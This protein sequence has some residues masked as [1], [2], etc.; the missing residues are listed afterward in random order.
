[1]PA[2]TVPAIAARFDVLEVAL[3]V[4]GSTDPLKVAVTVLL[5]ATSAPVGWIHRNHRRRAYRAGNVHVVTGQR[6]CL[7]QC[8]LGTAVMV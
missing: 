2:V 7:P 1:V 4:W 6:Q 5:S 3:T 8:T